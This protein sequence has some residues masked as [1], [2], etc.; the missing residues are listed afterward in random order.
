MEDLLSEQASNPDVDSFVE[1]LA[2]IQPRLDT[3]G[4]WSV[5]HSDSTN[6]VSIGD[7]QRSQQWTN[8]VHETNWSFAT[9]PLN[10]FWEP[11][12]FWET[13]N[14]SFPHRF[15]FPDVLT[16]EQH[17]I[18]MSPVREVK[19]PE[20][21]WKAVAHRLNSIRMTHDSEA[22]RNYAIQKWKSIIQLAPKHSETGRILMKNIWSLFD[23]S[24]LFISL[25]DIF[26]S[27]STAT[28]LKRANSFSRF[29]VWCYR[30]GIEAIP[31]KESVVYTFLYDVQWSGPTAPMSFKQ[32]LNFAHG[33]LGIDGSLEAANS[34]R[35][36][37][38][39][40]RTFTQK[41][42]LKQARTLTVA[43]IEALEDLVV[44]YPSNEADPID[45]VFAGHVLF[46]LYCRSRWTDS[47]YV[48]RLELDLD[49]AGNG[50]IQADTLISKTST[51]LQKKTRFLPLTGP[52]NGLVTNRWIHQWL[53]LRE[54]QGL[55]KPNGAVPIMQ[56]VTVAGHFS[57]RALLPAEAGEWLRDLLMSCGFSKEQVQGVCSHSLKAT[58]LSWTAK[59]GVDLVKRQLLGYHVT[60][61]QQS[62]LHY[63]R[64]ELA[65][66]LRE[67]EKVL[68]AVRAGTFKPDSTRSGYF[69]SPLPK[70]STRPQV[71]SADRSVRGHLEHVDSS[72]EDEPESASS[73]PSAH[74][75]ELSEDEQL[76]L[77]LP[78]DIKDGLPNKR[79]R[80]AAKHDVSCMYIH[81]RWK[82]L[83]AVKLDD[84]S[85]L[86][87]G[88]L[89]TPSFKAVPFGV[90]F[91]YAKCVVCFGSSVD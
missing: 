36:A 5:I 79:T 71:H 60:S 30:K 81:T 18:I 82:T 52:V 63:S 3:A 38:F 23:D 16:M 10:R 12:P 83:H 72:D 6:T 73:I 2:P 67:L 68:A 40:K 78:D 50:F 55:P 33:V 11:K 80:T 51:T 47:L 49:E 7:I 20:H 65:E 75:A 17:N 69:V 46:V 13:S 14:H 48:S 62:S 91:P 64:D 34:S 53:Q 85:K 61:S 77:S 84:E 28:I 57:G 39:C 27:K 86:A 21:A 42:P 44:Q 26:S 90:D 59:Y 9:K 70:S 8:L 37:G 25:Q 41:K 56:T 43:Q 29:I 4:S 89:I 35:I 24:Q 32:S 31:V 88:R 45:V 74:S 87:C 54:E 76:V 22:K 1:D 15:Q 58:L 19:P 66:P